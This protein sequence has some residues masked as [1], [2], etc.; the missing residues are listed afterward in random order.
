[1]PPNDSVDGFRFGGCVA[2]GTGVALGRVVRSGD[3]VFGSVGCCGDGV[4]V[5]VAVGRGL[6]VEAADRR[7]DFI[8][9]TD[10]VTNGVLSS[11]RY[12]LSA[13]SSRAATTPRSARSSSAA[14][15]R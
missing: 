9:G 1:M 2:D 3:G 7:F 14:A 13:S 12:P 8:A 5:A 15:R 4:A 11:S 10:R 6:G